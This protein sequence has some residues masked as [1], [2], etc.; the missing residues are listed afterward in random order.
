MKRVVAYDTVAVPLTAVTSNPIPLSTAST[1]LS[2]YVDYTKGTEEGV[3]I[4]VEWN[5]RSS[6]KWGTVSDFGGATSPGTNTVIPFVGRFS[7]SGTYS[8]PIPQRLLIQ[9]DYRLSMIVDGKNAVSGTVYAV[10][11]T[12]EY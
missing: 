3:L 9:G 7:A 5:D 8:F 10:M 2:I 6:L 11:K 1:K 12:G 4:S